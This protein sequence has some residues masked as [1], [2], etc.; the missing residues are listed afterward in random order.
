MADDD[1]AWFLPKRYGYGAG[2]P[3]AWQ[4]WAVIAAYGLLVAGAGLMLMPD[5]PWSFIAIALIF[6]IPLWIVTQRKTRGGWRWR[7]GDE[8]LPEPKARLPRRV[9]TPYRCA[10]GGEDIM[11]YEMPV[12]GDRAIWDL[13]LSQHQLPAVT[14]ADELGVFAATVDQAK[15]GDA[16]AD[17]LGLDPFALGILLS[18][19]AAMGLMTHRGGAWRATDIARTYVLKDSRFYW[20]P[21]LHG[22]RGP[23]EAHQIFAQALRRGTI[24]DGTAPVNNWESGQLGV[25]RARDIAAFMHAH[26][27]PAS[28][29]AARSGVFAQSRRL[30]DVGGGSGVFAVA[31]AQRHPELR[32]SVMDLNAM[33]QAAK[34]YIDE[35]EVAD[36]VDTLAVDMFREPWPTGYDTLFFSNIFHDWR[37]ETC[38]E[39]AAKALAVLPSGGRIVLHEQLMNDNLDGPLTTAAFSMLMLMGTRGKQYSL[40][41]FREI[42]EGAGFTDVAAVDGSG[43]Y[44]LVTATKP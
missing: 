33:C 37:P 20:G 17:E 16:L 29:G 2:L 19:L 15:A 32:A 24:E 26:S 18:M 10:K 8:D 25:E 1:N 6:I 7:W 39:L 35:G 30:L 3:I 9:S 40:P 23:K 38:R 28:I 22:A 41:E 43:Y 12:T 21:L 4:G 44:S 34:T 42:L 5:A 27:L 31:V 36:R 13:W 14:V 11:S